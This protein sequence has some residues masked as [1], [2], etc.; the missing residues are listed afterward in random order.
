VVAFVGYQL[1]DSLDGQYAPV[2]SHQLRNCVRREGDDQGTAMTRSLKELLSE[3]ESQLPELAQRS[4]SDGFAKDVHESV[5]YWCHLGTYVLQND[6]RVNFPVR[7]EG[8]L[9]W[10]NKL[11]QALQDRSAEQQEL[12]GPIFATST[13]LLNVIKAVVPPKDGHLGVLKIIRNHFRFLQ[14]EYNF[15]IT[16][17]EPTGLRFSSGAI[18]IR[19]EYAKKSYLSCQFGPE[20]E[21]EHFFGIKDLLFLYGDDRYRSIP[22][23][24]AL[25]TE[26]DVEHWFEFLAGIFRQYGRD[27]LGNKPGI[28]E[29]LSSAQ[30]ERDEEY[31]LEMERLSA[32][33]GPR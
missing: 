7:A 25:D 28:F 6:T 10:L 20:P 32:G 23:D 1:F 8:Q 2:S 13:E 26:R 33:G 29:Q 18:Y 19:L 30:A 3:L 5:E 15:A 11:R 12:Y 22:D 27:V 16:G 21:T 14:T 31:R 24:L 17:E 9:Q 4:A